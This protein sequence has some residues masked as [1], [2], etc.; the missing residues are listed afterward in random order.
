MQKDFDRWNHSKKKINAAADRPFYHAR[1]IW[2]CAVGVNVGNE[3]DGTGKHHDRPVLVLRPFNAETLFWKIDNYD[4]SDPI[5]APKTRA[6]RRRPNV[7]SPS[8]WP[9]SIEET[10]TALPTKWGRFL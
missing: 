5:S 10:S 9:A 1:E 4:K 3:L 8:C 6:I 7:S 2:W